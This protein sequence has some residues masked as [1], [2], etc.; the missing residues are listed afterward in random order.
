MRGELRRVEA[1]IDI[2]V[3]PGITTAGNAI[4]AYH[5]GKANVVADAL[6][7][8]KIL[9]VTRVVTSSRSNAGVLTA[10]LGHLSLTPEESTSTLIEHVVRGQ[11]GDPLLTRYM[12]HIEEYGLKGY[13]IDEREALRLGNQLCVPDDP[14]LRQ[15]I[16][17]EV[18]QSR[19]AIYPGASKMYQ[20]L[21]QWYTSPRVKRDVADYVV[22]CLTCQQAAFETPK[23]ALISPPIIDHL[24]DE[25]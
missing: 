9:A 17:S 23:K 10:M 7:R 6:S 2:S 13:H 3:D 4:R 16:L 24:R 11:R 21:R 22:R 5:P 8:K 25:L 19:L 12:D 15:E 18:H 1:E 14:E 20:G